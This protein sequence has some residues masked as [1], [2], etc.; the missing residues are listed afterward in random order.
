MAQRKPSMLL[1]RLLDKLPAQ[2]EAAEGPFVLI[3]VAEAQALLN[4]FN[5]KL[6]PQGSTL[7]E[8]PNDQVQRALEIQAA[9]PDISEPD[10]ARRVGINGDPRAFARKVERYKKAYD[11]KRLMDALADDSLKT[12]SKRRKQQHEQR[13]IERGVKIA[14]PKKQKHRP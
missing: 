1:S 3:Q 5:P 2:I 11:Q 8:K 14:R 6:G 7:H 9:E 13:L 10:L 12:I 4:Y